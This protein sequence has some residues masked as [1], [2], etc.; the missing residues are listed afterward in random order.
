[1]VNPDGDGEYVD[2]RPILDGFQD[3]EG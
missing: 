1:L 3:L 2:V